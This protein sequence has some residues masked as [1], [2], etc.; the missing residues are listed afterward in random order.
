LRSHAGT[1]AD[2][3][4]CMADGSPASSARRSWPHN[5]LARGIG[6][7]QPRNYTTIPKRWKSLAGATPTSGS[8]THA[9]QT[10]TS[11]ATAQLGGV[12]HCVGPL[13][14]AN[15]L[16]RNW[17][18]TGLGNPARGLDHKLKVGLQGSTS[19]PPGRGTSLQCQSRCNA[20]LELRMQ[21]SSENRNR[22]AILIVTGVVDELVVE[23]G[24]QLVDRKTVIGL[25]DLFRPRVRQDAV[26]H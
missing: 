25:E 22:S 23:G 14:V 13:P 3:R 4:S 16:A 21:A 18:S 12:G 8:P 1:T 24:A 17:L 10:E 5:S 11:G 15:A 9:R 19:E 6:V 2:S 7:I 26:A 20:H